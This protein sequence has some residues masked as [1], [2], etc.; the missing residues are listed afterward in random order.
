MDVGSATSTVSSSSATSSTS[1]ASSSNKAQGKSNTSFDE[2]LKNAQTEDKA[3]QEKD[4]EQQQEAKTQDNSENNEQSETLNNN[5]QTQKEGEELIE[6]E[7]N[8]AEVN[9]SD[10]L[11]LNIRQLLDTQNQISQK[12]ELFKLGCSTTEDLSKNIGVALDFNTSINMNENDA[13]FFV[14]LVNNNEV[15]LQNV[16]QDLQQAMDFGTEAVQKSAQVSKTLLNALQNSM[17][18]GQSVRIDFGNDVAVIMRVAKDGSIMANF[19]PG[20]KAVEEYLRNN[21]S[22]LKQRFDE[23]DIPYSQLS[24]SQQQNQQ[25]QR[26]RQE[27]NK[28][29]KH[30]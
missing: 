10:L 13:Q 23:E 11:S 3:V 16:V 28:E 17:K 15:G 6:V 7:F 12:N 5:V 21:I 19:I 14:D 25:E 22:S 1:S 18:T 29:N 26:R 9:S 24:Y 8:E 20:D 4:V 27:N 30:E 2:E